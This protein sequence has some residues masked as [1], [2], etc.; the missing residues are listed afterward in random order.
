MNTRR[1]LC[2]GILAA[3]ASLVAIGCG[4][5]P[6]VKFTPPFGRSD[7]VELKDPHVVDD[8]N[9]A[10]AVTISNRKKRPIWVRV[11]IDEIEGGDDC[12]NVFKLDVGESFFFSC[13]QSSVEARTQYRVELLVFKD[14]GNTKVAERLNRLVTIQRNENGA[15]VL[16]GRPAD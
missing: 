14:M 3:L 10:I 1:V 7:W 8:D 16:V 11:L 2:V 6:T 13:P 15:L 12:Q 9:P 5:M 4:W